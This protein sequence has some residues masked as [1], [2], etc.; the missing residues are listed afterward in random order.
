MLRNINEG[1]CR[2]SLIHMH[3]AKK[4]RKGAVAIEWPINH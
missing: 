1:A 2:D 4:D 3:N